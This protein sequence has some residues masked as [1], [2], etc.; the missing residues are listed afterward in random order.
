MPDGSTLANP[1]PSIL[2]NRPRGGSPVLIDAAGWPVSARL[3]TDLGGASTPMQFVK[4]AAC[5]YRTGGWLT[6]ATYAR[7]LAAKAI[8]FTNGLRV[9]P[10]VIRD[11]SELLK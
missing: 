9:E 2:D 11:I 10:I 1:V 6:L 5:P 8:T 3:L 7:Q 4:G